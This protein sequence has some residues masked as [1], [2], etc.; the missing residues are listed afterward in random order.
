MIK[1]AIKFPKNII[2]YVQT[3]KPTKIKT[4]LLKRLHDQIKK[5]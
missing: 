3:T 1:L 4:F 5:N 2:A